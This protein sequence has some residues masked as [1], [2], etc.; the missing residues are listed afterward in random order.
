MRRV[1]AV[2]ISELSFSLE[3]CRVSKGG[4]AQLFLYQRIRNNE[5]RLWLR[6]GKDLVNNAQ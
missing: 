5:Y 1:A 2:L 4:E 3:T 6:K